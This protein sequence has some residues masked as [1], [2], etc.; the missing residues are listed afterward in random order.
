[1]LRVVDPHDAPVAL[2][3]LLRRVPSAHLVALSLRAVGSSDDEI[4]RFL[5][6]DEEAVGPL[7]R[8]AL[9]KVDSALD[10]PRDAAH[11]TERP[12]SIR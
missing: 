1:M 6:I 2:D 5:S 3:D 12:R 7:I 9:A 4:A 11:H 10:R 8:L